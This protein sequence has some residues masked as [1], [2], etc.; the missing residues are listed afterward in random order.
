MKQPD[1]RS[2][3]CFLKASSMLGLAVAFTPGT[4]GETIKV[5]RQDRTLFAHNKSSQGC[6]AQLGHLVLALCIVETVQPP[7]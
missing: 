1:D 6:G 7:R 5:R 4:T 2:R 3:R